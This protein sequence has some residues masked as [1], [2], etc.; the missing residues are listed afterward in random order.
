MRGENKPEQLSTLQQ[1]PFLE[2]E[3]IFL[4]GLCNEDAEGNYPGWFNLQDICI[5]NAHHR[6]P[7]TKAEAVS[8]VEQL[9]HDRTKLVFAII[10][11]Q[12]LQHIGNISLNS[13]DYICRSAD[14]AFIIGEKEY[15]GKGIAFEAGKLTIMHGFQ[16]LNL[17]RVTMGTSADNAGMLRLAEKL[18]F[19]KEGARRQAHYKNGKYVDIIEF[20]L[21]KEEWGDIS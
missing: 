7:Y 4:R 21:L 8:Y 6:F 14:I 3:S 9:K 10:E 16:Q 15:W 12:N 5:Y 1:T 18:G 17:H 19:I 20:G 13:I 11:K 2:G